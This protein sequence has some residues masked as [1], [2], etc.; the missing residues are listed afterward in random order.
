V[1]FANT[2]GADKVLY[3]GYFPMGL[4]LERIFSELPAVG[5]RDHVWPKFLRGN[6]ER[7]LKIGASQ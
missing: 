6:A 4:S 3:A 2:R 1:Y 5:F 7:L